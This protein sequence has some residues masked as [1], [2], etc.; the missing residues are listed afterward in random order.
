MESAGAVII[1]YSVNVDYVNQYI[2]CHL[3][4]KEIL[5]F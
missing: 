3:F 2:F 1:P 4:K 5:E